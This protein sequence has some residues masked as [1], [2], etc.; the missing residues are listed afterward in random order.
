M[1][2]LIVKLTALVASIS[3]LGLFLFI[4]FFSFL[5]ISEEFV[6]TATGILV[7][8]GALKLL[9]AIIVAYFAILVGDLVCYFL[10]YSVNHSIK[11]LAFLRKF[12]KHEDLRFGKMWFNRYGAYSIS[13]ARF[14]IGVRFQTFVFAG[15]MG[16]NLKK[17]IIHDAIAN[18][19]FTPVMIY[20]GYILGNK[21]ASFLN[22]TI[23]T[24]NPI[25]SI[26]IFCAILLFFIFLTKHLKKKMIKRVE[27]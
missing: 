6:L 11:K 9:P 18:I 15:I 25:V 21:V 4:A 17:F 2:I 16:M 3:Y 8:N 5:A 26:L 19:I 27:K 22:L 20:L 23:I 24:S 12:I 1:E 10:G 13:F 7:A 14:I